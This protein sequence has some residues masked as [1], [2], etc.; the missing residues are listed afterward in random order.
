MATHPQYVVDQ[1]YR[2]TGF[3]RD[4]I[5]HKAFH[6]SLSVDD[7]FVLCLVQMSTCIK[8]ILILK[9]KKKFISVFSFA[10]ETVHT[11]IFTF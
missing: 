11:C 8:A 1:V 9:E 6:V 2:F 4:V 10:F 7:Y 3:L 5:D